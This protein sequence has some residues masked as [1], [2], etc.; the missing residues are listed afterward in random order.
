MINMVFFKNEGAEI[1]DIARN[2]AL[3]HRIPSRRF[4]RFSTRTAK[5]FETLQFSGLTKTV[6][7]N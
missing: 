1:R 7:G 5:Q 4:Q 3:N 6:F 2:V